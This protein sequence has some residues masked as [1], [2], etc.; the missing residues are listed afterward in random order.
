MLSYADTSLYID[1][2]PPRKDFNDEE[3]E[4]ALALFRR[5]LK[6]HRA[7]RNTSERIRKMITRHNLK[8]VPIVAAAALFHVSVPTARGYLALGIIEPADTFQRNHMFSVSDLKRRYRTVRREQRSRRP[9]R[10]IAAIVKREFG[11]D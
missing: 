9:L 6:Q 8:C 4:Q 2:M 7:R 1:L 10:E 5:W 3:A 11:S